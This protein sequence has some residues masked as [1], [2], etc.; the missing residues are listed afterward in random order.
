MKTIGTVVAVA[1]FC[2]VSALAS[3]EL[4]RLEQWAVDDGGNGHWYGAYLHGQSSTMPPFQTIPQHLSWTEANE[5][6]IAVGGYLATLTSAEE[7]EFVFALSDDDTLWYSA[8]GVQWGPW[9]GATQSEEH[10]HRGSDPA[11]EWQWVTGE[12]FEFT[13]W[14]DGEPNDDARSEDALQYFSNS[15][16]GRTAVWNDAPRV[17]PTV[18][19]PFSYVVEFDFDPRPVPEP[20]SVLLAAAIAGVVAAGQCFATRKRPN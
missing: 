2:S 4:I 14:S 8:Y 15:S 1:L 20:A 5:Q 16:T 19:S 10:G 12:P 7:N 3:A 18:F 9:L 11:E 13:A 17:P 6:A